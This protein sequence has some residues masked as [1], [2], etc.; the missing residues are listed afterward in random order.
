MNDIKEEQWEFEYLCD[1]PC[2]DQWRGIE[3]DR[4][5]RWYYEDE[6]DGRC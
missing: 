2:D 3:L 5:E 6:E 1:H 4:N